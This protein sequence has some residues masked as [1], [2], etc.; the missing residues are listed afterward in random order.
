MRE[1]RDARLPT[2]A[3]PVCVP[4]PQARIGQLPCQSEYNRHLRAG[5]GCC[6]GRP[7]ASPGLAREATADGRHRAPPLFPVK[8]RRHSPPFHVKHPLP[9]TRR[10]LPGRPLA[11]VALAQNRRA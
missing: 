4:V 7:V 2:Y 9:E 11:G 10:P 1:D 6:G 5:P 8:H 3:E